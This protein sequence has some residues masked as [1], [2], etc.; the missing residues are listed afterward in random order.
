MLYF[1][2]DYSEGAHPKIMD[3][4]NKSNEEQHVGYGLDKHCETAKKYIKQHVDR[5]DIDIHFLVSGTQTNAIAI[6]AFLRP[7]EAVI[8]ADTGHIAVHETGAIEA[9]GHKVIEIQCENGK[10]RPRD[11]DRACMTHVDEHMVLPKMVYISNATELGGIYKKEEL[12]ALR[13]KCDEYNLY[14]Y[15]DGARLANA[16]TC[17]DNNL[18]LSDIAELTDAFYIGGTKNGILFGEALVIKNPALKNH[19]RFMIKQ[20]GG[21]L[22]KGRLLGI[23]F[24]ELFEGNLYFEISK[25]TNQMASYLKLGIQALGYRIYAESST[26]I[27]FVILPNEIHVE[28]SKNVLLRS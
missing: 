7:F 4:L 14:L 16:L 1:M 13:Q 12:K 25:H 11:I 5:E 19:M 20:R 28:L 26:N 9:T 3:A 24:K 15:M 10:I 2:N 18:A 21:M 8:S 6:S 17:E 22:A 23:Q 27:L